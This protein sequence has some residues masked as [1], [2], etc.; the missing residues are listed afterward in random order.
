V[1]FFQQGDNNYCAYARSC[2]VDDATDAAAAAASAAA[3]DDYDDYDYDDDDNDNDDN[4]DDAA[5]DAAD[6]DDDD[7]DDASAD[8]DAADDID[9]QGR[10]RALIKRARF[11]ISC[12]CFCRFK[13]NSSSEFA[14]SIA[15]LG[16]TALQVLLQDKC[17]IA[18]APD[19]NGGMC[20]A[21][22]P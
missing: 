13:A 12:C 21:H 2:A 5:D 7:D 11:M 22:L 8:A 3:D 19:G 1:T 9:E 4:D 10:Y 15:H 16:H 18:R 6:D 20:V 17:T 14:Q